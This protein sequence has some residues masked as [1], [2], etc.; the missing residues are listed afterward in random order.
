MTVLEGGITGVGA[1]RTV[2]QRRGF[3]VRRALLC[4]DVLGIVV[5]FFLATVLVPVDQGDTIGPSV[6][7]ILFVVTLPIWLLL[8]RMH[9]LYDRDEERADHSTADEFFGVVQVV[10]FGVWLGEVVSLVTGLASPVIGRL[11]L[12]WVLAIVLVT[13]ARAIARGFCRRRASYRQ[14][15]V[16]VGEGDIG[17]LVARKIGQHPEYGLDLL[18]FVDGDPK[19]KRAE[20]SGVTTLGDLERLGPIVTGLDVDRVIVAFSREPDAATMEVVRALRDDEVTVD[21]VPRLFELVGLRSSMHML[22]GLPLVCVPPARLSRSSLLI[23]RIVDVVM[24]S[25]L[26]VF[27]APLFAYAAIRVKRGSPGPVFF[28]QTRLGMGKE[29]FTALKFRTMEVD[30]DEESIAP[31][32]S[33]SGTRR[34]RL[35]ATASTSSIEPTT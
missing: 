7:S 6:E 26:L 19:G 28:R 23:K 30:T 14:R 35:A 4:A 21:V 12:F 11:V 17:Q 33:R 9:G 31:T 20:I 25:I 27:L 24:S 15:V 2:R 3:M 18:G 32:S 22:E 34:R 16:V 10:T 29:P 5:A 8:F 1:R 13:S